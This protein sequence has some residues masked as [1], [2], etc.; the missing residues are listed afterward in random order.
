MLIRASIALLMWRA[1]VRTAFVW[2][3]YGWQHAI[4][5][6]PRMIVASFVALIAAFRAMRVYL[7]MLGGA[8]PEWDKTAHHFPD[9]PGVAT[10]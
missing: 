5:A 1:V 7:R 6:P 9:D 4:W 8:V 2:R 10:A 3:A